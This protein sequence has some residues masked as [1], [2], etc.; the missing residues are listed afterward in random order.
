MTA[1]PLYLSRLTLRSEPAV[2]SLMAALL[3]AG[4]TDFESDHRLIWSLFAEPGRKR[5]FLWRRERAGRY[6][7]LSRRPPDPASPLFKVETKP[8]EPVLAAGDRLA[9]ALRV[10]ATV[11]RAGARHDVAMDLLRAHPP[12][13]R[14]DKRFTLA[15]KAARAWLETRSADAGFTLEAL[16]L[17]GYR[18]VRLRRRN[19]EPGCLGVFDLAGRLVVTEPECFVDRLA[20][21]F[22]RARA[23]GCGLM[24]IRRVS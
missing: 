4:K 21:G 15:E 16:A 22:G 17:E 7:V 23:F 6:F 12:G 19:A 5:D 8:F 14:A 13:A 18:A 9:F 3:P 1:T 24:L 11:D 2:E 10:N 20:R